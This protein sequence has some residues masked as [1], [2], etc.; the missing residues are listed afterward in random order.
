MPPLAGEAGKEL[1]VEFQPAQ[2]TLLGVWD[3]VPGS[4][5]KE[6]GACKELPDSKDGDR[7]KSDSYPSIRSFAHAVAIDEKRNKFKPLL[8]CPANYP[9]DDNLKPSR[10]EKWFPGAH[11]DVGGGYSDGDNALPNISLNWM[12]AILAKT[13]DF[14]TY[15]KQFPENA[16]GLAHWSVSDM[17]N[18][19]GMRCEDRPAPPSDAKHESASQRT[20]S[21]SILVKGKEKSYRYPIMC[22]D[23]DSLFQAPQRYP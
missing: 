15:P 6:F 20:G 8:L 22:A 5:F 12:V 9:S 19:P 2:I 3:T 14:P 4:S 10:I 11:A 23:E 18:I 16:N 1:G 13:Y 7:Y 21:P 17:S